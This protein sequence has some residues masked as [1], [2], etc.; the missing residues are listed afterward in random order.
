MA[1][2]CV[3][4]RGRKNWV[5][6]LMVD[7]YED[8]TEAVRAKL[9]ALFEG[10]SPPIQVILF[11]TDTSLFLPH[12]EKITTAA[13]IFFHVLHRC[14]KLAKSQRKCVALSLY[15]QIVFLSVNI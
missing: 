15:N 6:W 5:Q 7:W 12:S 3:V 13:V 10:Y 1:I 8:E 11:T 14:Q 2:D 9:Y 4:Y